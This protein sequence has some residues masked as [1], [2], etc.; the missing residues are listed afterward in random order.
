MISKEGTLG[1]SGISKKTVVLVATLLCILL[2]AGGIYI[3]LNR[4]D[5]NDGVFQG[6]LQMKET[7]LNSKI[8]GTIDKIL[9]KEGQVVKKGDVILT[10]TSETIEAKLKQAESA[11]MAAE[12]Q[13][14]MADEGARQQK[15]VQAKAK[16]DFMKTNLDRM[17]TLLDEGAIPQ[18]KYDEIH[19]KY[20]AAKED[21]HMALEG[22]RQ[23]EKAAADALVLKAEGAVAEVNSYLEDSEIKAPMDGIVSIINVNQG[24]LVSSGM[25][26]ASVLS[27]DNPWVEIN[28]EETKLSMVS[29][30]K[31]VPL[32]IP[33]YPDETFK[34]KILSIN[35]KPDFATKRATNE[36]G[37]FD[38]LSYGVKIELEETDNELYKGM[39][40]VVDLQD[41]E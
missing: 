6:T 39:T 21:Y 3:G 1:G 8:P 20:V 2:L 5:K 41:E 26:L 4:D 9:V 33:A 13:A 38:V 25:P 23:Q 28:V 24:E 40:V 10:L 37:D 27:K 7:D 16:F 12:A 18:I 14:S 29:V 36:N 22:A 32:K 19:L 30:G 31:E 11:K 17:K 35:E 15:V 34:G